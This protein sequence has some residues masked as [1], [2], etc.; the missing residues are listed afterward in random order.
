VGEG[1]TAVL[2]GDDFAEV[3]VKVANAGLVS[4]RVAVGSV[5]T[6]VGLQA[7]R[8]VMRITHKNKHLFGLSISAPFNF[9]GMCPS[10]VNY[11]IVYPYLH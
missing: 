5:S 8:T 7:T 9:S 10:E 4:F 3:A 11:K 1:I 2:V 6:C